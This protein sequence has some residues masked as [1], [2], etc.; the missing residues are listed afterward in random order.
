MPDKIDKNL[1]DRG[2]LPT[3]TA[4][5]LATDFI[6][7]APQPD[8]DRYRGALLASADHFTLRCRNEVDSV[9]V[10]ELDVRDGRMVPGPSLCLDSGA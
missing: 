2:L 8:V 5:R 9:V 10:D 7:V 6:E 4:G 1:T 3:G